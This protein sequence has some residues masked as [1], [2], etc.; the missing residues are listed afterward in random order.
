MKGVTNERQ[1]KGKARHGKL[2]ARQG[3]IC[4]DN[5]KTNED[6]LSL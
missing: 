5:D 3:K 4:Q 2:K 1:M 6:L